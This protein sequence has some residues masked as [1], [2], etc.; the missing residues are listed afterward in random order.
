[1]GNGKRWTSRSFWLVL[2]FG[3]MSLGLSVYLHDAIPFTVTV[4]VGIG[5][6]F[7]G[8]AVA[9]KQGGGP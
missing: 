7:A 8:K 3:I 1:M 9:A 2:V 5:G 6:W 4:N